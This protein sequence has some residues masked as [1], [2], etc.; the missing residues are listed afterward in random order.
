M[1]FPKSELL[2][3]TGANRLDADDLKRMAD[4]CTLDVTDRDGAT[5]SEV[6]RLLGVSRER[7]RQ[8]KSDGLPALADFAPDPDE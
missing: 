1:R 3:I 5:L 4:T 6:A 7:V 2:G 8:I